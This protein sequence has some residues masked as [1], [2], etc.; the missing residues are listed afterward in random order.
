MTSGSATSTPIGLQYVAGRAGVAGLCGAAAGVLGSR[1]AVGC[2]ARTRHATASETDT[3]TAATAISVRR[4]DMRT[5]SL[6]ELCR[7][8]P[9][10]EVRRVLCGR[11]AVVVD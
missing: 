7:N 1:V 9:L 8:D 11:D 2:S 10:V 6:R 5:R 4:F 3:A